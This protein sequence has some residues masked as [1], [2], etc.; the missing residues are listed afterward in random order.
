MIYLWQLRHL[1]DIAINHSPPAP[2]QY[3]KYY[4]P[5]YHLMYLLSGF[6]D[7]GLRVELGVEKGRGLGA[8]ALGNTYRCIG[9][10]NNLLPQ[11]TA[12]CRN[13]AHMDVYH[14]SSLPVP[15]FIPYNSI[16]L[17][18]IDTE[19]SY[20]MAKAEFEAY[21]PHLLP[22]AIVLFDDL[23]A[24]ESDVLRYFE[25]LTYPKIRND[26]LHPECGYGVVIHE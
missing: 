15:S 25:E 22:S 3:D 14:I 5:Y 19:H 26:K 23:L 16:S 18:H 1:I 20:A 10:D 24:Q 7:N 11:A 8:M 2:L 4:Q 12:L 6:I 13:V 21:K 17:L 9:L